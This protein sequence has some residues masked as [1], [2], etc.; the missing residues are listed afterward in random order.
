VTASIGISIYPNDGNDANDLIKF[1]DI[2]MYEAK[3]NGKSCYML[4]SK[5]LQQR[6]LNRLKLE[7]Y[8]R[9]ALRTG[10]FELYYQPQINSLNNSVGGA[11]AL[12]RLHHKTIGIISPAEF[13]PVAEET[14]LIIDI[15]YWVIQQACEQLVKWQGTIK[16]KIEIS[17]N[18]SI[19][20][21]N[22]PFFLENVERILT[23]TGADPS[24]LEIELTESIMMKN[25][26]DIIEK[27]KA[28]KR[29]GMKLSIDDFGTGYSSLSYLRRFPMDTLKIDRSF[30]MILSS[31]N[32]CGDGAIVKAIALMAKA[33]NLSIVVEG[34]ETQDQLD[35]VNSLCGHDRTLIQGYFYSKP[36]SIEL[37][38]EFVT[39]ILKT[40]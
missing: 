3:E 34:V 6:S 13:I 36:L 25:P 29:L 10:M 23:K 21:I 37:F 20:Q 17:V 12:L 22:Q 5:E 14:G 31:Q 16:N 30:V 1:S 7:E 26:E 15:G 8:M 19:K 33:L 40:K 35:C 2:A 9:D 32:D 27:L 28:I 4:Y 38:E 39:P 11:E 18:V 24:L